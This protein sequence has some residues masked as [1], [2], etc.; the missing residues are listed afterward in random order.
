M[1]QIAT[2]GLVMARSIRI[3]DECYDAAQR[4]ARSMNRSLAQQLEHWVRFGMRIEL[5]LTATQTL[6]LLE[7]DTKAVAWPVRDANAANG[8]GDRHDRAALRHARYEAD[9]AAGRRGADSL[10][11]IPQRLA[12]RAKLTFPVAAFGAAKSWWPAARPRRSRHPR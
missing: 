8:A 12:R 3:S 11:V 1:W 4:V 2:Y 5:G 6:A 10:M 7:A 9:V